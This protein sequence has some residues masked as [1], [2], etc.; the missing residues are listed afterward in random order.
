MSNQNK[1]YVQSGE[2]SDTV[3]STRVRLARNLCDFPFPARMTPEQMR[4]ADRLVRDALR[5]SGSPVAEGFDYLEMGQMSDIQALSLVERRLISPDFARNR[6]GRALLLQRDESISIMLCEEDHLRIQVMRPGMEVEA[7]ADFADKLDTLLDSRLKIA[8]HDQLG[9]LTQCPTNLGTGLRVSVMLHLPALEESGAIQR[10]AAAVS[11]IGLTI[12]G[13]YGEGSEAQGSLYQLSNQ[14]TLGISEAAA[15]EN[16]TKVAQQLIREERSAREQMRGIAQEDQI[17][18]SAG[19]LRSARRIDYAE[20]TRL[21]S[22]VRLGVAMGYL[23][24]IDLNTVARLT[25]ETAPA[26]LQL[27]AGKELSGE[28]RDILRAQIVRAALS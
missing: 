8:F 20:L 26:T 27:N 7:A 25:V 9:Y 22:Q 4:Q 12:R 1:W 14:V 10:I 13:A 28:E 21:L 23:P 17:H 24:E 18:R 3:V 5:D 15:A 19:I 6:E 11:K 2:Q 16:L